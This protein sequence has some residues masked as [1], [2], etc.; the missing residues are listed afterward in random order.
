MFKSSRKYWLIIAV[1]ITVMAVGVSQVWATPLTIN[2]YS[3]EANS[4]SDGL[5]TGS[6]ADWTLTGQG[7][8]LNP[9][10]EQGI[11]TDASNVA[12]LN[13]GKLSQVLPY[14]LTDGHIYTLEVDIIRRLN[15]TW[16]PNGGFI[17]YTVELWEADP[18]EGYTRLAFDPSSLRPGPGT[19]LTSTVTYT[20]TRDGGPLMI[21]L[22]SEGIQTNFDNVRLSNYTPNA[23]PEPATLLLLGSGLLGVAWFGKKRFKA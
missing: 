8:T 20:A 6:V 9:S 11:A 13:I 10:A 1:V 7:G 18:L 12:Y 3:F 14:N 2:N 22:T 16:R 4:L 15:N 17:G 21:R 23:V 19:Y 5:Y